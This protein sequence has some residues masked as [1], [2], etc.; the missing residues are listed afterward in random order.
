MVDKKRCDEEADKCFEAYKVLSASKR[1]AEYSLREAIALRK[2]PTSFKADWGSSGSWAA[3][4][5]G[6]ASNA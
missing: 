1:V 6:L 5:S 2:G 4:Q 3:C